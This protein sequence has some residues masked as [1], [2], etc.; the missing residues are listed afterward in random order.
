VQAYVVVEVEGPSVAL[1][2]RDVARGVGCLR[3]ED[4][5]GGARRGQGDF[6]GA[7]EVD[8]D[9]A[10]DGGLAVEGLGDAGHR[11][12]GQPHSELAA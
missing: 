7:A 6:V 5:L 9:A 3:T 1:D 11:V 2:P 8:E 4:V 10:V 12:F